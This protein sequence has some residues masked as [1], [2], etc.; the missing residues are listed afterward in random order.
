MTTHSFESVKAAAMMMWNEL[1]FAH[2]ASDAETWPAA[3]D[4]VLERFGAKGS[5]DGI[6]YA[7]VVVEVDEENPSDD[8][9]VH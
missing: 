8:T 1:T 9:T 4:A 7:D 6:T 3:R 5:M 2:K